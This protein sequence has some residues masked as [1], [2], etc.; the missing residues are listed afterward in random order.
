MIA[1]AN[2]AK[3]VDP[4]RGVVLGLDGDPLR[5][6]FKHEVLMVEDSEYG[7]D[8]AHALYSELS[9]SPRRDHADC[10]DR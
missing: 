7:L 4:W 10:P 8:E 2:T 1:A 3:E 9:D 5:R 6:R